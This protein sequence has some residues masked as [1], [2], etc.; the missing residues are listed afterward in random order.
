MLV[1]FVCG[2]T[3][4]GKTTW[5][6]ELGPHPVKWAWQYLALTSDKINKLGTAI[7][8]DVKA[9]RTQQSSGIVTIELMDYDFDPALR[10]I[11]LKPKAWQTHFKDYAEIPFNA[12]PVTP[13][14]P[15]GVS[16]E[17][18]QPILQF[19]GK[20]DGPQTLAEH[21]RQFPV[22]RKE[23]IT[24]FFR[25]VDL[26]DKRVVIF[27]GPTVADVAYIRDCLTQYH[28]TPDIYT[29]LVQAGLPTGSSLPTDP[30]LVYDIVATCEPDAIPA[31]IKT[32]PDLE[33]LREF[34][35]W[36]T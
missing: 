25:T 29:V 21:I 7:N 35:Y 26:Q 22:T 9:Q 30:T 20:I 13:T 23:T 14:K 32:N 17:T 31:L 1:L 3:G 15:G 8:R 24:N 18:C 4:S 10:A 11:G 6:A 2:A 28:L 27:D 19:I 36:K 5:I 16:L 12:W 33:Y 34:K